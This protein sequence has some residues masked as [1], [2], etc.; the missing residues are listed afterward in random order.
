MRWREAAEVEASLEAAAA[1]DVAP[2][3]GGAGVSVEAGEVEVEASPE[4]GGAGVSAEEAGEVDVA[5][6]A[7]AAAGTWG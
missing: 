1:V 4:A 5:P 7:G 3:A 6:G 2:E